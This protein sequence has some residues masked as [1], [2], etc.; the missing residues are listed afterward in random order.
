[1]EIKANHL[2]PAQR[3]I[4]IR[5]CDASRPIKLFVGVLKGGWK[6]R[7]TT[8]GTALV[9]KGLATRDRTGRFEATTEGH[10]LGDHC[11]ILERME[12]A[13]VREA[14]ILEEERIA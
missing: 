1:M 3:K 10:G 6:I 8:T 13:K 9:R 5:L 2:T 4:M 12:G 11:R 14:A 7:E